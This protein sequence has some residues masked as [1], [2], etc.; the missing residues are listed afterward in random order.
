ME[1][2]TEDFDKFAIICC[3]DESHK[4]EGEETTI[5]GQTTTT[6]H[7]CNLNGYF[8][9]L[10]ANRSATAADFWN[11]THEG[12][13]ENDAEREEH[14]DDWLNMRLADFISTLLSSI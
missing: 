11:H 1:V 2:R 5:L 12:C 6:V 8:S 10:T 7:T 13:F 4:C 14:R 3:Q 9:Y